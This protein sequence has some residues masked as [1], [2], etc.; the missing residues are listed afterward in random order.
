MYV[1]CLRVKFNIPPPP[2]PTKKKT[3]W[4]QAKDLFSK[5]KW[6]FALNFYQ[7]LLKKNTK[8]EENQENFVVHYFHNYFDEILVKEEALE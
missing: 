4:T 8:N 3:N 1:H 7:W 5:I 6:K 2:P